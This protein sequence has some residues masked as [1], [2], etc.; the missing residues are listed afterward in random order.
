MQM[1]NSYPGIQ[2]E[3][4]TMYSNRIIYNSLASIPI[5]DNENIAMTDLVMTEN[6]E[7]IKNIM[8]FLFYA[9]CNLDILTPCPYSSLLL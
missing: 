9:S 8:S 1:Q 7:N 5:N 6:T 3:S 2:P 4:W